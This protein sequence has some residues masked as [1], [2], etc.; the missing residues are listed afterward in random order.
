MTDVISRT[1][2][3]ILE[4]TTMKINIAKQNYPFLL[5]S[6][7]HRKERDLSGKGYLQRIDREERI[8]CI[9]YDT[10]QGKRDA[11]R[12]KHM[13]FPYR[14][15]T[16]ITNEEALIYFLIGENRLHRPAEESRHASRFIMNGSRIQINRRQFAKVIEKSESYLMQ[17]SL[18]CV[19]MG[20]SHIKA[21]FGKGR[22]RQH[23]QKKTGYI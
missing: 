3:K 8:P 4:S 19:I 10:K 21:L 11:L 14:R 12:V 13:T 2:G 15:N 6:A 5:L 1:V 9:R 20:T 16:P 7:N 22:S 23:K 18:V 17:M